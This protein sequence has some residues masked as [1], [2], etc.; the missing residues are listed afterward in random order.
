MAIGRLILRE[1]VEGRKAVF[2]FFYFNSF[3]DVGMIHILFLYK[4]V[5]SGVKSIVLAPYFQVSYQA[6]RCIIFKLSIWKFKIIFVLGV[7]EIVQ[8]IYHREK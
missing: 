2:C 4:V 7:T 3:F 1:E 8:H 5:P 6:I